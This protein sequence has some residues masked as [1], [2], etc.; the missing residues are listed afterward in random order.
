MARRHTHR[1]PRTALTVLVCALALAAA[2]PAAAHEA[3]PGA[4]GQPAPEPRAPRRTVSAWLPYWNQK[5]AYEDALA[6]S[7]QLR[8][9]SPFWYETRSA[10][11]V[12]GHTGSG[13]RGIIDGLHERGVRVVPTV[14]EQMNPGALGKILT[15]PAQRSRHIDTLLGV[16]R[17]R[18]YDGLD[19]DY[20]SIAPTPDSTYRA[21][22]AGYADFVSGLCARLHALDK[23]CIVTV[24]PKTRTTGRIWDYRKLGAAA[25]RMRIMGYNLHDAEGAPGPLSSPQWYDDILDTATAQVPRS[26]L[27]MGLPGYGWDW[28]VGHRTR[29]RH[30]TWH[31]AEALRRKVKAPYA[32]DTASR[33][34]HF[35]YQEKKTRRTV[36]YQ[37]ARGV[38][39]DLPTLRAHGVTATALWAL[40]F[41]DPGV[42]RVLADGPAAAPPAPRR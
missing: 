38:A 10:G 8:T 13:D 25:D 27:E 1:A 7:R 33:T 23:Q 20:E 2:L 37:D 16:V 40:G 14:M 22:R 26:K 5:A 31:D 17:S 32:L 4:P 34:P 24:T 39:A 29:A 41:E 19:I 9:V 28:A 21:V 35:T 30:V 42:W 15:S 6:H 18:A 11:R 36:W 12:V 3:A